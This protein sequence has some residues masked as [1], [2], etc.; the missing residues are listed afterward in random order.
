MVERN[1]QQQ[2][3]RGGGAIPVIGYFASDNIS[4]HTAVYTLSRLTRTQSLHTR[5]EFSFFPSSLLTFQLSATVWT[6]PS[7]HVSSLLLSGTCLH[8]YLAQGSAFP[9][10]SFVMFVDFHRNLV[11]HARA[12]SASQYDGTQEKSAYVRARRC[13]RED[14]NQHTDVID[15][16]TKKITHQ[17]YYTGASW[18]TD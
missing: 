10:F 17:G 7:S 9:L 6:K 13:P 2:G 3:E 16:S 5:A 14:S 11:S 1:T 4:S 8:F 15:V 12:L 18:V